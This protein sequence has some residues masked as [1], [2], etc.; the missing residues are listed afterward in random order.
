MKSL[1]PVLSR[2]TQ[3]HWLPQGLGVLLLLLLGGMMRLCWLAVG[4]LWML[5]FY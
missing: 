5:V 2:E 4:E 1:W 3:A